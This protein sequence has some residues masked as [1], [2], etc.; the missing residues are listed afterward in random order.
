MRNMM[1]A[2]FATSVIALSGALTSAP[3]AADVLRLDEVAVGELDPAK[4]RDYADSILLYNAYDTLVLPDPGGPGFAPHLAE[5]FEINEDG[6]VYTFKLRSGVK[7]HSGNE[8]TAEDVVF[9]L[10]RM[11]TLA[12]GNSGLFAGAVAGTEAIDE[13]TVRITL[14]APFAPF[15]AALTRLGIVDSQTV[16]ANQQDGDFGEFGDYG[17]AYLNASSAGTGAYQV[18]SH[19]P[20][21]LTVL[22]RFDDYFL[23]VP[24]EAPD[25][26]RLSYGLEGSTVLALMGRGEHDIASQWL[27]PELKRSI[28]DFESGGMAQ[29]SG[30]AQFFI[31]L[32]TQQ[33][34]TD[35]KFCRRALSLAVDYEGLRSQANIAPGL[36]GAQPSKGP[37]VSG[38]LGHDASLPAFAQQNMEAARAELAKC[39]YNPADHELE[40]VWIAE[41]PLEE[42]FALLMASNFQELGFKTKVVRNPWVFYTERTADAEQT[43]HVNQL[44]FNARS[45]DPDAFLFTAYHSSAVGQFAQ[46]AW[47]QNEAADALLEQGRT[48]TDPRERE[49]IYKELAELIL[50]ER[51]TIYGY[52]VINTFPKLDRV[53]IPRLEDPTQNQGI[54]GLNFTFRDMS[55]E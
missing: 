42:R 52:E 1:K 11:L 6:T 51:P 22:A 25:T 17:Q 36:E 18:E 31:S 29:E 26:V 7:F 20:Q 50:D 38:M 19:D 4:G 33:P 12:Q 55:M 45:P 23:G 49:R 43:P 44:F 24:A 15:M 21:S 27:S 54:M 28:A 2:V 41:V 48:T 3:Q 40:V 5:S 37:I 47:F 9:S 16:R 13:R 10:D 14:K 39:K 35:D 53:S 46:A 34:P 32:N 30:L 8:L